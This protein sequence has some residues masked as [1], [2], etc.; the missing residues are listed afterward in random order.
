LVLSFNRAAG[1]SRFNACF[2]YNSDNRVNIPDLAEFRKRYRK[3]VDQVTHV[4]PGQV[5]VAV[6]DGQAQRSIVD[7]ITVSFDRAVTI[8]AGAFELVRDD[9]LVVSVQATLAPDGKSAR[10]TFTGP[11]IIGGSLADGVYT[12]RVHRGMIW[13]L[14][15]N[16]IGTGDLTMRFHRLFGDIDGDR[17]VD[18]LDYATIRGALGS[19][20]GDVNYS[21]LY[22]FDGDGDVDALDLAAMKLRL[23]QRL[24][25]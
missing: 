24:V 25:V 1:S 20:L 2:D 21:R 19:S 6:N 7:S 22:D 18:R 9:G 8:G 16:A 5:T 3:T 17:D 12:L 13:D 15:G 23:G 11:E 4:V 10:L 14:G